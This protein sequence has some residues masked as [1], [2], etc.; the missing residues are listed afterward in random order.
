MNASDTC[1]V[2]FVPRGVRVAAPV[3]MTV[4]QAAAMAGI[5]VEAPCGGQGNCGKCKVR[6]VGEN[7]AGLTEAERALLSHSEV[8]DGYRLACQV[9][10]DSSMT[11]HVPETPVLA[12][13][14]ILIESPL[15]RVPTQDPP[16]RVVE[17]TLPRP[18]LEDDVSDCTRLERVTG[19]LRLDLETLRTFPVKLRASGY[20]GAA[21]VSHGTLLDFRDSAAATRC[22]AVAFDIGTTT[23]AA[24][25]VDLA[26]SAE[27][28]RASRINPQVVFADDILSRISFAAMQPGGLEQMHR[29]LVETL[30]EMIVEMA[31]AAAV[32]PQDVYEI[33][34]A[35]NTTMQQLL[36]GLDPAP[37]GSSP[38]TPAVSDSLEF[39]AGDLGLTAHPKAGCYVFPVIAGYV[40]GDTVAGLVATRFAQMDG[41]ALFIDIGT[42]GEMAVLANGRVVAASCAAGPAFEGACITCGMRAAAGAIEAIRLEDE[43]SIKVIGG[44]PP[45][46]LCGSALIDLLGELL[47]LG[48]VDRSGAMAWADSIPATVHEAVRRRLRTID[49]AVSFVLVEPSESLNGR[50]IA[51]YQRD[52]R[53]LQLAIAAVRTGLTILLRRLDLKAD[54]LKTVLV[55]GAFGN[56]IRCHQAQRIGLLPAEVD[57]ERIVFVGNT[58]LAGARLAALSL[59]ERARA[60]E[61]ALR[62]DHVELSLDPDF[63]SVF[64]DALLFPEGTD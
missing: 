4:R 53:Q 12:H 36:L 10:V 22:L 56:Y 52:V 31:C 64:V 34:F 5:P 11:V 41:P 37:I 23:L 30:N 43:V 60:R 1:S 42:N 8:R 2:L 55:A 45:V 58:S 13:L 33:T 54:R 3:G 35:G 50:A 47:R 27:L 59:A 29:K 38:F 21:V 28:A 26:T 62:T 24:S 20:R 17:V 14:P 40:G 32:S 7:S 51:L 44:G 39:A 19:P 6:I 48:I 46:G 16:V 18:T 49:D 57:A 63:E 15:D 61:T 25:L 9:A